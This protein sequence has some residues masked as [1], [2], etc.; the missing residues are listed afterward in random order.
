MIVISFDGRSAISV[1]SLPIKETISSL[2]IF[3]TICPGVK[4]VRTSCP[5]A[6][7]CTDLINC[8]TTLKLT[9][10]SSNAILT[11][12]KAAFTSASVKRPLFLRFLKTFCN[13]SDKLSNAMENLLIGY[14]SSNILFDII[15][16]CRK[17]S[18]AFSKSPSAFKRS[19]A[20]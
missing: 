18:V 11:S 9:S 1:V 2:T 14:I 16:I 4:L 15:S 7:S 12:F 5:M 6:R 8:L 13:F 3:I 20:S 10:A 17:Y 19:L